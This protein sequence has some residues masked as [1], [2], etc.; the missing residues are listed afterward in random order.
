MTRLLRIAPLP[1]LLLSWSAGSVAADLMRRPGPYVP[2]CAGVKLNAHYMAE[3]G[4]GAGPGFSFHIANNTGKE[5]RLEQPVPSSAHWYAKVGFR[6]MWRA[7]AGRGGALVDAL[8]ENGPMF[9][10]RPATPPEHAE[11]LTVPAKGSADWVVPM[12]DDPAIAYRPSCARCNYPGETEYQAVFA[13]AY[14]PN[15]HERAADLLSCG[16]RSAP[17]PMPPVDLHA[18]SSVT[19]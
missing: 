15:P 9:A 11:Y 7:S 14:L 6:W 16:L 13:Y 3:V 5:I 8:D 4:A 1:L 12:R 10:Y 19:H 18:A 17:A 2:P